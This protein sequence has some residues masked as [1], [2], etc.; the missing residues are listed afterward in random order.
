M[1]P[2]P[3]RLVQAAKLRTP[4]VG[5]YDAPDPSLFSPAVQPEPG[6]RTCIFSFF[7]SWLDG[8]FLHLTPERCGCGGAGRW[9]FA[10]DTR[11]RKEF[12][13][14]LVDEEGLRASTDLMEQWLDAAT[15][16]R[17]EHGHL[18]VGPLRPEV[19]PYLKTVSFLV[20]PDQLSLLIVGAYY[21]AAPHE[22]PPVTAPFGSGCGQLAALFPDLS[23]P[24]AIIGGTDIAMRRHLP[25][26]ILIFTAT[27]PM[28]AWLCSLDERSFLFKPFWQR[29]LQAR[30]V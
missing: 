21:H 16:Y 26:D 25:P 14:F 1:Q 6:A 7:N 2:N 29:L 24:Q 20:T 19:Y 4:I 23:T 28:F 18:F 11:P 5:F 3:T 30:D 27:M 13:K 9:F 22:P 15:P 8:Q 17:P 12:V 10:L